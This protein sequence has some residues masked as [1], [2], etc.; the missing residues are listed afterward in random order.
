MDDICR[1]RI[2]REID[3]IKITFIIKKTHTIHTQAHTSNET[4][5]CLYSMVHH[6][7]KGLDGL[8]LGLG[9]GFHLNIIGLSNITLNRFVP[10]Q[11]TL[12]V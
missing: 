9:L 5:R 3:K 1:C 2:Y 6:A 11:M 8:G 4:L 10:S 7:S 12:S